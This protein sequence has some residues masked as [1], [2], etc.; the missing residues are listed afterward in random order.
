MFRAYFTAFMSATLSV[1]LTAPVILIS[2]IYRA[3]WI[4]AWI[5][6]RW[7]RSVLWLAGA[8]LTIEGFEHV[9]DGKPRIYMS[10]HQSALDIPILFQGLNGYVRFMAKKS[11][12]RIPFFGWFLSLYGYVPIDRKN[13]R[14]AYEA[15]SRMLDN[16]H[17]NPASIAVFPEGTRTSNG[18]LLP[19]HRGTMKI[20]QRSGLDIVPVIIDGSF[21]VYNR[22]RVEV[23]PGPV[24]LV[25]TKPIPAE[26]VATMTTTELHDRVLSVI[27]GGLGQPHKGPCAEGELIG[28]SAVDSTGVMAT[29]GA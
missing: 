5:A 21:D 24:K 28:N 2:P 29:E 4:S 12:F 3:H 15:L 1:I 22:N 13:P 26:E 17:K 14:V 7:S 20:G 11:L 9:A 8:P 10:N 6:R 19:F 27:A 25:F 23:R 16:L 18:K